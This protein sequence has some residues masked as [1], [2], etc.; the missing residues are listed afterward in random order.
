MM[1]GALASLLLHSSALI[2]RLVS[3]RCSL[4]DVES[5]STVA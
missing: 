1:L 2:A 3:V 4:C 5:A